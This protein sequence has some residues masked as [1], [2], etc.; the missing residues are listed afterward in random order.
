MVH[1]MVELHNEIPRVST[2]DIFEGLGYSEHRLLKKVIKDNIEEFDGLGLMQL[3]LRKPPAGSKGGRPDESFLLDEEQFTLLVL[4][5]KNNPN[6]IKLKVKIAKQ[7]MAMKT[8]LLRIKS[9]QQSSEW[10]EQRKSGKISRVEETDIIKEFVKYAEGQGSKSASMYYM[11]ISRMENK[12]LFILESKFKNV[13]DM[14]DGQQLATLS[15]CDQL[16][17]KTLRDC[18]AEGIHYKEIYKEAKKS[19]K[20]LVE[21][22]GTSGVPNSKPKAIKGE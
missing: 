15:T 5:C 18:M 17:A 1:E 2:F 21:L 10:I 11:N 3:E 20:K 14:L 19:V 13:R 22:I 16:V 6:T 8:E 4:L 12:A 7:F 9:R